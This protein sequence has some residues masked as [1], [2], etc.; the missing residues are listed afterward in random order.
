MVLKRIPGYFYI[1]GIWEDLIKRDKFHYDLS[2]KWP[3]IMLFYF[4]FTNQ[5]ILQVGMTSH[6]GEN[7]TL[8]RTNVHKIV[9]KKIIV[10]STMGFVFPK[11]SEKNDWLKWMSH[12]FFTWRI[13]HFPVHSMWQKSPKV[14]LVG[15]TLIFSVI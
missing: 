12:D 5:S 15:Y 7:R 11:I 1:T 9:Y 8:T 3:Q 2:W 4:Q 13:W 14:G 6:L 10:C